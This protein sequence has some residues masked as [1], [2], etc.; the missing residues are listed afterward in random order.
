LP[1]DPT[2]PERVFYY[3]P[4]DEW[5]SNGLGG[6]HAMGEQRLLLPDT[7]CS[8]E[9]IFN[10]WRDW[11]CLLGF[12]QSERQRMCLIMTTMQWGIQWRLYREITTGLYG[13]PEE[14]KMFTEKWMA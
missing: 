13:S 9:H 10:A 14:Q 5:M 2:F 11:E 6:S 7:S 12:R 8:P 4:N 1:D 3:L